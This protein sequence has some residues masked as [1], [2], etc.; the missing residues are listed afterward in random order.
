MNGGHLVSD[1]GDPQS[2][3]LIYNTFADKL[4]RSNLVG[5]DVRPQN[6]WL[7]HYLGLT[8]DNRYMTPRPH[9]TNSW[10]AIR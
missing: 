5:Q 7:T 1:I 8:E 10:L 4:I 3:G 6:F 9:S 2:W